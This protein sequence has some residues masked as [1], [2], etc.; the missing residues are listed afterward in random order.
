MA[1][2][3]ALSKKYNAF[4][5]PSFEV[6]IKDKNIEDDEI[7]II[8]LR[9]E[10]SI[11]NK[12]N[13]F[14][15]RVNATDEY[16]GEFH[17][18]WLEQYFSLGNEVEI[19]L[20]YEKTLVPVIHGLITNVEFFCSESGAEIVVCGMD[21]SFKT[22]L[23]TRDAVMWN[24][25]SITEIVDRVLGQYGNLSK[26]IDTAK[27][28][29][30]KND[31]KDKWMILQNNETDYQF[32][33]RLAEEFCFEF[34][35]QNKTVFFKKRSSD[36]PVLTLDYEENITGL[37]CWMNAPGVYSK[38]TV[39]GMDDKKQ[40]I[41]GSSDAGSISTFGSGSKTGGN[42]VKKISNAEL[43]IY[44]SRVKSK[45]DAKKAAQRLINQAAMEFVTGTCETIGIPEILPGKY[46]KVDGIGKGINNIYYVT[47]VTQ[48][49]GENG[50]TT[51]FEFRGNKA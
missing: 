24:A 31:G 34:Y 43:K 36:Q 49:F 35:V 26:K 38:V 47:S 8:D 42:I 14:E 9:V 37:S 21:D 19:K 4:Y 40:A 39:C 44:D 22:M 32:I 12:S 11:E 1:E 30:K 20:G 25:N 18:K 50:Y 23:N 29:T 3:S 7:E 48:I 10:G 51:H 15:F 41:K 28:D 5:L 16:S 17:T 27:D 6:L 2:E 33:R 46:I 45:E 13:Y